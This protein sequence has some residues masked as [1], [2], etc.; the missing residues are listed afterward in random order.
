ME[1]ERDPPYR[2]AVAE[3]TSFGDGDRERERERQ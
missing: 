3:G 2:I 1:N